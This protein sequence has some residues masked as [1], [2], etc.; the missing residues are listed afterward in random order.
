[1]LPQHVPLAFERVEGGSP[2]SRG[3]RR[4]AG[5][6]YVLERIRLQLQQRRSGGYAGATS[7]IFAALSNSPGMPLN[8]SARTG[9]KDMQI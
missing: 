7:D 3:Q 2:A 6:E 5:H 4:E 9:S 8:A 1:M